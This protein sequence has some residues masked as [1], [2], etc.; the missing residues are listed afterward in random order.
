[1]WPTQYLVEFTKGTWLTTSTPSGLLSCLSLRVRKS[2][3]GR[4]RG[5]IR[6]DTC[7]NIMWRWFQCSL[8]GRRRI[9]TTAFRATLSFPW[10]RPGSRSPTLPPIV[11]ATRLIAQILRRFCQSCPFLDESDWFFSCKSF[12]Q[13]QSFFCSTFIL[14][15]LCIL[16]VFTFLSQKFC[17]P[18]T[19]KP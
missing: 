11:S 15:V 16:W 1:M 14:I 2:G 17:T 5:F 7:W 8:G 9:M 4:Y 13:S 10:F 18:T 3:E 6:C 12:T 19:P